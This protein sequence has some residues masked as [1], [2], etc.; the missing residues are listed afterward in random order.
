MKS[1]TYL[2]LVCS[3]ADQEPRWG[4]RSA[5]ELPALSAADVALICQAYPQ[6]VDEGVGEALSVTPLLE[7]IKT[8]DVCHLG[9]KYA[10]AIAEAARHVVWFDVQEECERREQYEAADWAERHP[11]S[12]ESLHGVSGLFRDSHR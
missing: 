3:I 6:E 7:D 1:A 11:E 4:W 2:A 8:G 10:V 9:L 12:P 5:L